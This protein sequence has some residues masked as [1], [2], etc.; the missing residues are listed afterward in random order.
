VFT[1]SWVH[2]RLF[3]PGCG[4]RR[5]ARYPNNSPVADFH[6]VQCREQFE[7]KSQ[8]GR[9]GPKVADGAYGA[10]LQ[11]LA[12]DDSPNLMPTTWRARLPIRSS[13]RKPGPRQEA[14]ASL[15]EG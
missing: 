12:A 5:I 3:C 1:E 7:L 2:T 6:C 15:S 14:V 13:R 10:K 9:F 11:R 8:R 4:E